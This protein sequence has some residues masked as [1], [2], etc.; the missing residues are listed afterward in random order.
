METFKRE[1]GESFP[2]EIQQEDPDRTCAEKTQ[3]HQPGHEGI[4]GGPSMDSTDYINIKPEERAEDTLEHQPGHQGM[5][6][7]GLSMDRTDYVNIKPEDS[8]EETQ[9]HQSYNEKT[10]D[11]S[12]DDKGY[13]NIK[14]EESAEWYQLLQPILIVRNVHHSINATDGSTEVKVEGQGV[15]DEIEEDGEIGE[16]L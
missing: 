5:F 12:T 9:E 6:F 8:A 1:S 16:R 14:L 7:G 13:I 15:I 4:F 10:F 2:F 11:P 3:E